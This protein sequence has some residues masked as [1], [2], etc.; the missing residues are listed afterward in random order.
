MPIYFHKEI[1]RRGKEL[2]KRATPANGAG[3]MEDDD[4]NDDE[5]VNGVD[6]LIQRYRNSHFEVVAAVHARERRC[7][8]MDL[9][10]VQARAA[11]CAR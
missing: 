7:S 11:A 4:D 5:G 8:C 1:S 10:K 3:A 9:F 2:G 6:G